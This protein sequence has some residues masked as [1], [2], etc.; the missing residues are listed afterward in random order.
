M[1]N[2]KQIIEALLAIGSI[3]WIEIEEEESKREEK[4][5][6]KEE[7]ERGDRGGTPGEGRVRNGR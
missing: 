7:K 3:P 2:G 5:V 1:E 6:L 4:C